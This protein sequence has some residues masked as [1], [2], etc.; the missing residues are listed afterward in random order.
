VL[1]RVVLQVIKMAMVLAVVVIGITSIHTRGQFLLFIGSIAL[2][3]I[4]LF[5]LKKLDGENSPWWPEKPR[6]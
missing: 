6:H 3:L 1:K 4:C 5:L 2:F